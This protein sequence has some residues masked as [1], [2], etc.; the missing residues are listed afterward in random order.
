MEQLRI[1]SGGRP[2]GRLEIRQEGLYTRFDAQLPPAEG[3]SRL[4]LFDA[5][6]ACLCLGVMEPRPG[7]R[8]LR[9]R[10][11]RAELA[12]LRAPLSHAATEP[13]GSTAA[14]AAPGGGEDGAA[15]L[16]L[17]REGRRYLALPCALRRAPPGLRLERIA[18]RDYL[19]FRY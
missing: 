4:Y 1:D 10:L 18:G 2:A 17:E 5:A 19:L 16:L 11:S 3:L 6:G 8:F 7:G 14:P 12:P 9:R 13:A 15:A